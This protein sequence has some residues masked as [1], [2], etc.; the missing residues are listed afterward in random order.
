MEYLLLVLLGLVISRYFL[1]VL[2][3]IMELTN[4]WLARFASKIVIDTQREQYKFKKEVES[5]MPDN[6]PKI[7]FNYIPFK[8]EEIYEDDFEDEEI[9]DDEEDDEDKA[10][11]KRKIK[12]SGLINRIINKIKKF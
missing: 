11:A 7:G 4:Y 1:P 6:S 3:V 10:K 8:E 2:D 12:K 5:G 9:P